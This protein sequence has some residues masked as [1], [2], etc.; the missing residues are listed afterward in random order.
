[1]DRDDR[2][3]LVD[4][5]RLRGTGVCKA[6][7]DVV[8]RNRSQLIELERNFLGGFLVAIVAAFRGDAER[9]LRLGL[10]LLVSERDRDTKRVDFGVAGGEG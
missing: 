8:G 1:M 4:R 10:G 3:Q 9:E 2:S 6:W 5:D 7:C